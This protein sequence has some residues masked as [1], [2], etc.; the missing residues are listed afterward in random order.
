VSHDAGYGDRRADWLDSGRSGYSRAGWRSCGVVYLPPDPASHTSYV[1]GEIA[2]SAPL[3]SA[4]ERPAV[5]H[6]RE[7]GDC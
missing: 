4:Q 1:A 5:D 6:E 7:P 3:T 2:Q